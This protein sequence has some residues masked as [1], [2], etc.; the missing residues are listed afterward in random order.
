MSNLTYLA[1]PYSHKSFFMRF[2]RLWVITRVASA[3]HQ[4]GNYTLVTPITSSA[5]QAMIFGLNGTWQFWQKIDLDYIDQCKEI[6]VCTMPGW[7]ESVGV[8][9]EIK[10][11]TEK[12]IPVKFVDPNTLEVTV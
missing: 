2:Y 11:A 7:R 9:A 10:Y 8:T 1:S 12:G 5:F 4:T 3:L 6:L